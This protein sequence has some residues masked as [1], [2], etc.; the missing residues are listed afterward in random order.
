MHASDALVLAKDTNSR[1]ASMMRE[2]VRLLA[3]D[4]PVCTPDGAKL[5]K[6]GVDGLPIG[7]DAGIAYS[8]VGDFG[9]EFRSYLTATVTP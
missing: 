2:M 7:A 4:A 1:L 3:V 6:L 5:L 9:D 8:L